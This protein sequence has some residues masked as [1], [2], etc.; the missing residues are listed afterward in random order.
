M[1]KIGEDQT[2]ITIKDPYSSNIHG[3]YLAL[4][5][6]PESNTRIENNKTEIKTINRKNE[7]NWVETFKPFMLRIKRLDSIEKGLA[8]V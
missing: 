4:K 5:D 3:Y 7:K 1:K 8:E 6:S 2:Y